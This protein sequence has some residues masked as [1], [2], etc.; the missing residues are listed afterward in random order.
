[1]MRPQTVKSLLFV[2]SVAVKLADLTNAIIKI[3]R[4]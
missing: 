1:L 3:F 4:Q 2:L